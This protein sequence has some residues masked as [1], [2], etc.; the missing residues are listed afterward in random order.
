MTMNMGSSMA[1]FAVVAEMNA[2]STRL[3]RMKLI[4]IDDA[5][6]PNLIMNHSANRFATPVATNMLASTN[7]MIFSH[8]TGCPSCARAS[9]SGTTLVRM[10]LIIMIREVR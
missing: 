8:M 5:F 2:E 6:F 3:I 10:R 1:A 9:F 4:K 7:D